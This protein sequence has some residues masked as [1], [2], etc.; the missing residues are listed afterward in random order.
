MKEKFDSVEHER[1][2]KYINVMAELEDGVSA[3]MAEW[4]KIDF[5]SLAVARPI[6]ESELVD[7]DEK[8]S[9]N[10]G[11]QGT[12]RRAQSRARGIETSNERGRGR[13]HDE[14]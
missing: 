1:F 8:A 12:T 5:E 2:C 14:A 9:G 11:S 10:R 13:W 3:E 6:H 7:E 4:L